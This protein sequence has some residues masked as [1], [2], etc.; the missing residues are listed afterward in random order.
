MII[1][2]VIRYC[3]EVAEK[4][5]ITA[6]SNLMEPDKTKA[7]G[8]LR[9]YDADEYELCMKCAEEHRQLAEWLRELKQLREQT[10]WIP[11]SKRLPEKNMPCLVAVDNL[12][13]T[14]IAMYS[15]CMKTLNHKIFY[16]GD[17]GYDNFRNITEYVK[18][19]MPLPESYKAESEVRR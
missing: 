19:W 15:D 16:Q 5:E 13:L 11:V 17:V 18:A 9:L 6:K 12:N 4:Q 3:E 14:Q 1:D 7:D 10:Q 2:E 8:I